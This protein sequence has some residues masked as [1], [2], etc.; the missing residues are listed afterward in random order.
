MVIVT[1]TGQLLVSYLF[2]III[3]TLTFFYSIESNTD[4]IHCH[5]HTWLCHHALCLLISVLLP[6]C[7]VFA[8]WMCWAGL[9][10][11]ISHHSSAGQHMSVPVTGSH[12]RPGSRQVVRSEDHSLHNSRWLDRLKTVTQLP[13]LNYSVDLH[14]RDKGWGENTRKWGVFPGDTQAAS[15]W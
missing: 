1:I 14:V 13:L 5:Y 9:C 12:C 11:V 15:H 4:H 10:S 3:L 8:V 7:G 6:V 2:Y